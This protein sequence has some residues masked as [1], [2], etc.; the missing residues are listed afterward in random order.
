MNSYPDYLRIVNNH[1]Q[2][3]RVLT[4]LIVLSGGLAF[5][6]TVVYN[7]IHTIKYTD[8]SKD[9]TKEIYR[10]HNLISLRKAYSFSKDVK[11]KAVHISPETLFG[12]YCTRVNKILSLDM[13]FVEFLNFFCLRNKFCLQDFIF[14]GLLILQGFV[15][16]ENFCCKLITK[17][18]ST[19]SQFGY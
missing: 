19:K 18:I 8:S 1:V 3:T 5:R 2:I 16:Q 13:C 7:K 10:Q 14:V 11:V 9:T 6:F 15:Y 4:Q 17:V 12:I